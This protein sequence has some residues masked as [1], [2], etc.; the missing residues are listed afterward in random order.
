MGTEAEGDK[1]TDGDRG[2]EAEGDKRIER[3]SGNTCVCLRLNTCK[4]GCM[5]VLERERESCT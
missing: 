4:Y 1:G 2:T 3:D 5:C